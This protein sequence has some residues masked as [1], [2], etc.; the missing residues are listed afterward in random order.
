MCCVLGNRVCSR[1]ITLSSCVVA[2]RKWAAEMS[3]YETIA[4]VPEDVTEPTCEECGHHHENG[5]T[6]LA[7]RQEKNWCQYTV[8]QM[9]IAHRGE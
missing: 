8:M 7:T 4:E 1:R 9:A 6:C 2:V 5:V 3:L